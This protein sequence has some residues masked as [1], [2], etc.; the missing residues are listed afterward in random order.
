[1]AGLQVT[2]R[3]SRLRRHVALRDEEVFGRLDLL[4]GERS[5]F[6]VPFASPDRRTAS[7][8]RAWARA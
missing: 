8:R 1:M 4:I 6:S 2:A 3:L 7:R 5:A